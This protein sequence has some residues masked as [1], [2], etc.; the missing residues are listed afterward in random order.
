MVWCG[1][2]WC[3]VGW[4]GVGCA[5]GVIFEDTVGLRAGLHLKLL[6]CHRFVFFF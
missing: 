1:V 6:S 4:C 5:V 2:V 3:G